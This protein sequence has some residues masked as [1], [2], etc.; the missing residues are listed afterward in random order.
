MTTP[1]ELSK[2]LDEL[3]SEG[4]SGICMVARSAEEADRICERL[5]RIPASRRPRGPVLIVPRL[6]AAAD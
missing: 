6:D 5:K 3:E 2:R 4:E 1:R